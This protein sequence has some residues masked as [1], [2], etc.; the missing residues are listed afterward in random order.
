MLYSLVRKRPP[1]GTIWCWEAGHVLVH[2]LKQEEPLV[3]IAFNISVSKLLRN[4]LKRVVVIQELVLLPYQTYWLWTIRL[5][6]RGFFAF[7]MSTNF[8]LM[9]P[10]IFAQRASVTLSFDRLLPHASTFAAVM[11]V[12]TGS[13]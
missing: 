3:H 4:L 12:H 13:S 7:P 6:G 10:S 11:I 9:I 1:S 5:N 8:I 2:S